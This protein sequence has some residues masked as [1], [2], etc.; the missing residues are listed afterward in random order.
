MTRT[1]KTPRTAAVALLGLG[2][3]IALA[4]GVSPPAA[5]DTAGTAG[6]DATLAVPVSGMTATP[7]QMA[8]AASCCKV[9]RAGKACG[10]SCIAKDRNC[11]Q[12]PGCACDGN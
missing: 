8:L 6:A 12:P 2:L 3:G 9:C 10:N 1:G 4:L 11:Y 7:G 5:A